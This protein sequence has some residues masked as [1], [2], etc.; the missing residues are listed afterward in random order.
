M[1][2]KNVYF[3]LFALVIVL[4]GVFYFGS[5]IY[6]VILTG[7]GISSLINLTVS[8]SYS[9]NITSPLSDTYVFSVGDDYNITLNVTSNFVVNEWNYSLYDS[10]H[11]LWVYEDISFTP[12]TTFIAT[13]WENILIVSARNGTQI[14]NDSVQFNVS[15]P[16][17]APLLGDMD[18]YTICQGEILDYRFNATDV[19]EAD[20][21]V[22]PSLT[23]TNPFYVNTLG[24]SGDNMTL[25]SIFSGVL[26][27]GDVGTHNLNVS[28]DDGFLSDW[29]Y[30][31]IEVLISSHSLCEGPAGP[32]SPGGGGGVSE[33]IMGVECSELWACEIWSECQNVEDAY[34]GGILSYEKYL[35]AK[36]SC[37]KED[38]NDTICGFQTESCRDVNECH[39]TIPRVKMPEEF[40]I[41]YYVE[42]PDC[43]DGVTNC[44]DNACE[45]LVDC[46]GPC[47][48]C[49]TCSDGK[50]NQ[51]EEG[52]DCGGPC[53]RM[54]EYELASYSNLI[55]F[56]IIGVLI[57]LGIL[58]IYWLLIT[59]NI[60]I[61]F[62][63]RRPK[64][65]SA[66]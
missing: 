57:I 34:N 56:G 33:G 55:L 25:F 52:I 59:R 24:M 1:N 39:N 15:V 31:T 20:N 14:V 35:F 65:S 43:F 49:S 32:V 36:D 10:R 64:K 50:K 9:V 28:V 45:V 2:E 7:K 23:P 40:R 37:V 46:G 11:G 38:Y 3:G 61:V 53:P 21:T 41:C 54:C 66:K 4:G 12:N 26:G 19:D 13:R 44:H 30:V 48:A 42:N 22:S 8:S 18:N 51:G 62:G 6:S 58:I 17:S 5:S 16:N 47:E 63:Y 60:F 27:S 29:K